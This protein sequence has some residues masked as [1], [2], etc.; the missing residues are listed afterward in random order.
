MAYDGLSQTQAIS[1]EIGVVLSERAEL[2]G[3]SEFGEISL[4]SSSET[5]GDLGLF[6]SNL[7]VTVFSPKSNFATG[8]YVL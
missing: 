8:M 6:L 7:L 5:T 1:K 2:S 3:S 4:D